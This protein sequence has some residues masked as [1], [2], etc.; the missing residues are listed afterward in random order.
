MIEVAFHYLLEN[1]L[2]SCPRPI[3]IHVTWSEDEI[4]GQPALQM[5][6]RDNGHGFPPGQVHRVF[7]PF[8]TSG[9]L[10]MAIVARIVEGHGG[11]I[12]VAESP[13]REI[14]ITLPRKVS[15]G[16]SC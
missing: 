9:E 8:Y 4:C 10:N 2:S 3:E 15:E 11:E 16:A 14:L 7:E 5:S 13:G 1:S 12:R 6:L